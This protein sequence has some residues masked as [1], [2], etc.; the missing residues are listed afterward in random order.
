MRM[1]WPR[2]KRWVAN[3][4]RRRHVAAPYSRNGGRRGASGGPVRPA[5]LRE[6]SRRGN[7]CFVERACVQAGPSSAAGR[8]G[9][10]EAS[11]GSLFP[12]ET[13]EDVVRPGFAC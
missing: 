13:G 10:P 1:S 5:A 3:P 11:R 8:T 6:P 7:T 2:S 4:R 12:R 9:P